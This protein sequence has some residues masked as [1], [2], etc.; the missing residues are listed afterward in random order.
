MPTAPMLRYLRQMFAD[1]V[2]G[3][4]NSLAQA[5]RRAEAAPFTSA[6]AAAKR[7]PVLLAAEGHRN[8]SI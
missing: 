4:R 2:A 8:T 6:D 7:L 1:Y 5:T 3:W